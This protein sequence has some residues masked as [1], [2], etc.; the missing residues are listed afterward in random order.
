ME[1]KTEK[2]G[3]YLYCIAGRSEE[4][5]LG[6]IGIEGSS[7]YTIPYREI[8]AVVHNCEPRPYESEDKD[9]VKNWLM[10]HQK[11]VEA[12]W[13]RFGAILPLTFDAIII[14]DEDVNSKENMKKWLQK[15]YEKLKEKLNKVKGKAE[16]GI[17]ILW[18]PNVMVQNLAQ[19]IPEIKSLKEE[20]KSKPPGTAYMYEE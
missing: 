20:L 16:Y 10:T 8:S 7:I 13:Q 18:D 11:V 15:D 1:T 12:A 9:I 19:Q 6:R 3:L 17:Q 5:N 4:M 14:G 2:K